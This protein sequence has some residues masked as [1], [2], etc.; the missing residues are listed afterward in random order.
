MAT[1]ILPGSLGPAPLPPGLGPVTLAQI[2]QEV[3]ARVG[4]FELLETKDASASAIA[5]EVLKSTIDLGGHVA[6]GPDGVG[7]TERA[8]NER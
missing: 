2:E 4:P 1:L 6:A 5:V 7:V 3:A 8:R